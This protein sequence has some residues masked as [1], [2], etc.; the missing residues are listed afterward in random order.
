MHI[1]RNQESA[2]RFDGVHRVLYINKLSLLYRVMLLDLLGVG[3]ASYSGALKSIVD[4]LEDW[5][6]QIEGTESR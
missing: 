1:K 2:K 5:M 4:C 3:E 6:R